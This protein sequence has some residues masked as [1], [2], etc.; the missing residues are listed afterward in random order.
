MRGTQL[1]F[2]DLSTPKTDG[3]FN[4]YDDIKEK[5]IAQGIPQ[6]EIAFIHQANTEAQKEELFLP[7]RME[8]RVGIRKRQEVVGE[9]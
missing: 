9:A 4:V 6:E 2:C 7:V 5:L 8:R 1:V 3:K